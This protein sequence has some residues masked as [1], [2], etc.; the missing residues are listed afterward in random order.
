[1]EQRIPNTPIGCLPF[2]WPPLEPEPEPDLDQDVNWL[3]YSHR[4]LYLMVNNGLDL[5]RTTAVAAQWARLGRQLDDIGSE[6]RRALDRAAEDWQGAAAEQARDTMRGLAKWAEET[7]DS[8]HAVSGCVSDQSELASAAQRNMPDPPVAPLPPP[9]RE[10]MSGSFGGFHAGPAL[11]ADPEPERQ[12]ERLLHRQAAEVMEQYQRQSREL[13]A[14]VPMFSTP[15]SMP[16]LEGGGHGE[17]DP[18]AEERPRNAVHDEGTVASASPG[19]AAISGAPEARGVATGGITPGEQYGPG[20]RAGT[21]PA[22]ASAGMG[23][24][25]AAAG[26][27]R[28]AM[29]PVAMPTAPGA[30]ARGG[31]DDI[32]HNTPSYLQEEDDVWGSDLP[33]VPPVLGE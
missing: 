25:A 13:H 10:P 21:T 27:S 28:G 19:S 8:S 33:V 18:G 22:P 16:S 7:A 12:H 4:E 24:P 14:R 23:V 30:G 32:E 31:D 15:G 17:S 20:S 6:L 3:T 29:G 5:E 11:V 9:E 26:A 2:P 1:M